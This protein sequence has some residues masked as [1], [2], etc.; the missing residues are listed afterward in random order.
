MLADDRRI[1]VL[2]GF[3]ALAIAMVIAFHYFVSP[4]GSGTWHFF[5]RAAAGFWLIASFVL[6]MMNV[7][8]KP[9]YVMPG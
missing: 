4:S 6:N 3:R 1:G 5:G 9:I 7:P 2:D 8:Y